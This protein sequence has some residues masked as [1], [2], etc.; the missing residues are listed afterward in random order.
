MDNDEKARKV[1]EAIIEK[2]KG[3][4]SHWTF[5]QELTAEDIAPFKRAATDIASARVL[6]KRIGDNRYRIVFEINRPN[7]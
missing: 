1:I 2:A 3:E 4:H 6:T 7:V 5:D